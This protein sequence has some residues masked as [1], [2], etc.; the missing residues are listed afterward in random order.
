MLQNELRDSGGDGHCAPRHL[1]LG[2]DGKSEV[3]KPSVRRCEPHCVNARIHG[4]WALRGAGALRYSRA[5]WSYGGNEA[6]ICF[7]V[8]F[9]T[10]SFPVLAVRF[11]R[12][13]RL[14]HVLATMEKPRLQPRLLT[15][16]NVDR[17][18]IRVSC[19][20]TMSN[21]GRQVVHRSPT[22][23]PPQDHPSE[24]H[25]VRDRA[26][27]LGT[28]LTDVV[29]RQPDGCDDRGANGHCTGVPS[30]VFVLPFDTPL[31]LA[32]VDSVGEEEAKISRTNRTLD[33]RLVLRVGVPSGQVEHL[34]VRFLL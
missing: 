29:S 8:C 25:A 18:A 14:Y 16:L 12:S 17:N 34:V 13:C 23:H 33:D 15:N 31:H 1:H 30:R 4:G 32:H 3:T 20:V 7:R 5:A 11:R 2:P 26:G 19:L 21:Q 27:Q 22:H 9:V 6:Q 24:V 28:G 10:P